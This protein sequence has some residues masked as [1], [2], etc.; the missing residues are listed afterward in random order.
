MKSKYL[1]VM[2]LALGTL[3]LVINVKGITNSL[4]T[5]TIPSVESTTLVLEEQ[6]MEAGMQAETINID[7][8]YSETRHINSMEYLHRNSQPIVEEVELKPMTVQT[9]SLVEEVDN[10]NIILV[11]SV[12][13]VDLRGI[14]V[15]TDEVQIDTDTLMEL[16]GEV[17]DSPAWDVKEK[18]DIVEM[19][20]EF[21]VNQNDVDPINA[22]AL[23]GNIIAEGK[24]AEQQGTGLFLTSIGQARTLLGRGREGYGIVQWTHSSRQKVLLQYY[25]LAND[26]YPDDWDRAKVTAECAMLIEEVKAYKIFEDIKVGTSI[27]D[28][29]GRVCLNYEAYRNCE[30]QWKK[31]N[32]NYKLVSGKGT[33]GYER[34][35]YAKSVYEYFMN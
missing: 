21:L 2:P 31:Q 1:L 4:L 13:M 15:N 6:L 5:S 28:A 7:S 8:I 33:N 27:E 25:E 24:F 32:G 11:D 17:S 22:S 26:I 20:W 9:M 19:L 23:I 10:S 29:T 14:T 34:L 12:A 18:I 16:Y 3:L 30:K 35:S